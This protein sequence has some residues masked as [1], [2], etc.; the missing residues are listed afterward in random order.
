V[1]GG[2]VGGGGL[3]VAKAPRACRASAAG[4][5]GAP[6]GDDTWNKGGSGVYTVTLRREADGRLFLIPESGIRIPESGLR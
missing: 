5:P 4:D 1:A 6:G 2:G 3:P